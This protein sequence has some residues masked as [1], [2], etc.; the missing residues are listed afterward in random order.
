MLVLKDKK[1]SRFEYE[2]Q[3]LKNATQNNQYLIQNK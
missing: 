2:I 1:I 3:I